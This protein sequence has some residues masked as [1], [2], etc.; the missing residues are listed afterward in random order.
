MYA[1]IFAFKN[2]VR[3][4]RSEE[5]RKNIALW[6]SLDVVTNDHSPFPHSGDF[7]LVK[8][9]FSVIIYGGVH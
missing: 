4:N 1:Y 8:I 3:I 2:S 5:H 7:N 9:P 6:L